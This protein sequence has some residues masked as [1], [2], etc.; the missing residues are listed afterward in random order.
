MQHSGGIASPICQEGQSERTFL[1]FLF[2]LIFFLFFLIFPPFWQIFHYHG[3]LCPPL[4][5]SD[6]A[7]AAPPPPPPRPP[8]G[9]ATAAQPYNTL[10]M[11]VP[12]L[13]LTGYKQKEALTVP[14]L[15]LPPG[16]I[17]YLL[18]MTY[19]WEVIWGCAISL[20]GKVH[21]F[22]RQLFWKTWRGRG[23]EGVGEI[24]AMFC[25]SQIIGVHFLARL[26]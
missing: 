19:Y 15:N 10:H 8:S 14:S 22:S 3:A 2:F 9:Y 16:Q 25:K 1:I 24:Q 18:A 17:V 13:K 26:R 4:T 7:T 23:G 21:F 12:G 5:P 11:W 20:H 6:Y